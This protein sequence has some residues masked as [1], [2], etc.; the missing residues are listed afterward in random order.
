MGKKPFEKVRWQI[1]VER[2]AR[3]GIVLVPIYFI[4]KASNVKMKGARIV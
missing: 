2:L 3:A 4:T 1:N